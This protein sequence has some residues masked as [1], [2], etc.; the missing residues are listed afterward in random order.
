MEASAVVGRLGLLW[1]GQVARAGWLSS[2]QVSE[3]WAILGTEPEA[4][5]EAAVV[6]ECVA[7]ASESVELGATVLA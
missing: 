4:S 6:A 1:A 3:L 2:K 7:A 5:F